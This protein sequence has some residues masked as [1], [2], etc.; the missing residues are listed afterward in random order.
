MKTGRDLIA[1]AILASEWG[2]AVECGA[3]SGVLLTDESMTL[4]PE[5]LPDDSAGQS[6]IYDEDQGLVNVEGTIGGYLRYVGLELL[7]ALAMGTAGDPSQQ[8]STAAYEH[9]LALADDLT[10]IFGTLAL[11]KGVSVF[12]YPSAKVTGFEIR[13]E[14]GQPLRF[15]FNIMADDCNRNTSSG[16][17]TTSTIANVTVPENEYRV[18]F[19]QGVYRINAQGGAALDGDDEIGIGAFTLS[20][21]RQ[22]ERYRDSESGQTTGEPGGVGFPEVTLRLEF[23]KYAADTYLALKD[24]KTNQKM[25]MTFT[26]ATIEGAYTRSFKLEFPNLVPMGG[27][28]PT[29]SGAARYVQAVEFNCRRADSAPTGMSG[30][31]LPFYATL[32]STLTTDPLG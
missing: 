6:F 1:A 23:P 31:T 22:M 26:G 7:L 27:D 9:V 11:Y 2:T 10:G 13:G 16:T 24:N 17:N 32:M 5:M 14:V 20:F 19:R 30:L 28:E 29:T 4:T 3:G 18:L 15:T 8:E 25:D 12:E 21:N